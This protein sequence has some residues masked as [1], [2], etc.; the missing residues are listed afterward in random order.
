MIS[1][2]CSEYTEISSRNSG[3]SYKKTRKNGWR[4][5]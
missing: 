4:N 1:K 5:L 2:M 3:R